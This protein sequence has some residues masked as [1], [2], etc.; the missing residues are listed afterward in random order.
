MNN[1][2]DY[3]NYMNNISQNMNMINNKNMNADQSKLGYETEPYL[4]FIRGN[5][6][7]NIYD[8][9]QNYQIQELNPNNE[10]EYLLLLVQMYGFAA[11]DLG[12]YLDVNPNDGKAIDL[13]NNYINLYNQSLAN[14]E[15]KYGPLT[16]NSQELDTK[17]WAWNTKKWPWEGNK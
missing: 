14:Y 7:S 9:Y 3:Y 16:L 17:P 11:H 10:Q 4:G 1:Y 13:R 6:F 2:V 5:M 12:L 8:P 15:S